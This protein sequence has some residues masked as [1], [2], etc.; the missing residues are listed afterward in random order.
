MCIK[1]GFNTESNSESERDSRAADVSCGERTNYAMP[2]GSSADWTTASGIRQI[3][4]KHVS[5]VKR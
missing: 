3:K 5:R 4:R 1:A 2:L